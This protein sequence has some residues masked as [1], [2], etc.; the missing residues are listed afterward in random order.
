MPIIYAVLLLLG[1]GV[2]CAALLTVASVFFAVKEDER[3]VA[4]RE[5]LPGANCGSCGFSG[6]DGYAKALATGECEKTNLCT[7]G[8][9]GVARSIAAALGVE[10][11]DVVEMVAHVS[12]NG[13][14]DYEDRKYDYHGP[15]TC[16][17]ANLFYAGDRA[18][19]YAC[20]GYGDCVRV[21]PEHAIEISER[22]ISVVDQRKCIG[23]GICVRTCPNGI[24][25]LLRDTSRV[26]VKCSNHDK[27]GVVRKFCLDGC[28]GCGKCERTCPN[29]AIHVVDNLAVIDYEKC[30][31]CGKCREACPV[32]CIHEG[33]FICGSHFK[34]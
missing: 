12:C 10:A 34:F 23:C 28:I 27:G 4:I 13:V 3:A 1:V 18:C 11:E 29:D 22:G 19:T 26:V 5:C 30:T 16:R 31:A 32:H 14:C 6:C 9:D 15:K 21:C 8:G 7:P 20:L 2:F 17:S 24:I 33:N 25:H